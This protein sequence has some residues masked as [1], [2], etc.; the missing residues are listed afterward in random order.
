MKKSFQILLLVTSL[1]GCGQERYKITEGKD[2]KAYRLDKKTGEMVLIEDNKIIPLETVESKRAK[3]THEKILENPIEWGEVQI[4]GHNLKVKLK[5]SW[6]ESKL[7]YEFTVFPYS[8]LERIYNKKE[9]DPYYGVDYGFTIGLV[10]KNSFV[11]IKIPISLWIMD[12]FVN[13]SGEISGL[14]IN[15]N[16]GLSKDEYEAM[17]TYSPGWILDNEF[18][19]DVD[20][21]FVNTFRLIGISEGEAMVEDYSIGKT[22]FIAKGQNINGYILKEVKK[23]SIIFEKDGHVFEL[24]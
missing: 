10:D 4:P 6:R 23:N 9:S 21:N 12:K 7:Y 1:L 19:A 22:Y 16:I 17:A 3:R 15:S 8:S 13:E 24:K 11:I 2:G 14:L 5:T 18:M 20:S